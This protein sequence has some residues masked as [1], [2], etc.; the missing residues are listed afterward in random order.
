M[1]YPKRFRRILLMLA[2]LVLLV[3]VGYLGLLTL[4]SARLKPPE[5]GPAKLR[6][7]LVVRFDK[8]FRDDIEFI[9]SLYVPLPNGNQIP[10]DQIASVEI[11]SGTKTQY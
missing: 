2:G 1:A 6:F 3:P 4:L 9:K 8:G 7:D 11:K 5:Y 10:M